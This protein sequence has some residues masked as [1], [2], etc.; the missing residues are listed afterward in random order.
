M[1]LGIGIGF[2]YVLG[3]VLGYYGFGCA[4]ILY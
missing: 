4:N 1:G 2:F 3:Q